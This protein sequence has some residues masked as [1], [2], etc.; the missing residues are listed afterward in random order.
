MTT[1]RKTY[2]RYSFKISQNAVFETNEDVY[3]EHNK[4][5]SSVSPRSRPIMKDGKEESPECT[6][7]EQ[8]M[9][10]SHKMDRPCDLCDDQFY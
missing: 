9:K 10:V 8:I 1:S 6:D 4:R 3:C 2:N 7:C 5:P